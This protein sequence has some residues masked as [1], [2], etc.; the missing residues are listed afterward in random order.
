VTVAEPVEETASHV[1][2][3]EAPRTVLELLE[4]RE[5]VQTERCR[6][7]DHLASG[8]QL[9]EPSMTSLTE[10]YSMTDPSDISAAEQTLST[11]LTRDDYRGTKTVAGLPLDVDLP[12]VISS[13]N[14]AVAD[15][16]LLLPDS[17]QLIERAAISLMAGHLILEGPP[18]TGKT[19]LAG[20]LAAAFR[21]T[22]TL[23][24][25]TADWS[26]YD[27]IGGLQP[28]AGENDTEILRPWLGHVPRAAITCARRIA[29]HI[30][31][32][33]NSPQGHWL[34]ID[35]FNRAD[36]D[37]A[38]G[39][40]Y[41][42][43]GGGGGEERRRLPLWF[44]ASEEA[45][46]CWI[47]DRFRIIGTLN[48]VD[49]AYVFTLSQGLQRRF[50][51]V[52]VGVPSPEQGDQE[53]LIASQHA[54]RWWASTYAS[55]DINQKTASA[56]DLITRPEYK[57]ARDSVAAFIEFVRHEIG[58]P[59]GTAQV[60]DVMRQVAIRA[61]NRASH[62]SL[63]DAVDLAI[64]D[65]I[66]PQMSGLLRGQ[67]DAIEAKLS[68]DFTKFDHTRKALDLTRHAQRTGF[69]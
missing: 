55:G 28:A 20:I 8:L 1:D 48:S 65:H 32:P 9:Q 49:T 47:P 42:V 69:S 31:E 68:T 24:T 37:K 16:G 23:E 11:A 36:A 56:E 64:S 66:V 5:M 50:Q 58:W 41:T 3:D 43:L 46:E 14:K 45:E 19:T 4:P 2:P 34:I 51:F 12:A 10:H 27:V 67:L 40:L 6:T 26:T 33:T 52:H 39:P 62:A 17:E 25:A 22:H 60:I 59:V 18:G 38:I 35:E 13:A 54:A 15:A 29:D 30:N 44:G 53:A 61:S 63:I 7:D 57:A 21:C